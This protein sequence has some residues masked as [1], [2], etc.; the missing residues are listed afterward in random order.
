VERR[1]EPALRGQDVILRALLA[2]C[3]LSVPVGLLICAV[4]GARKR[5][6]TVNTQTKGEQ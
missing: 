4:L 1:A 6:E 5:F 3:V 2:W